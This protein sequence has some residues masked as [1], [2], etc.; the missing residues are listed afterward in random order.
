LGRSAS[1]TRQGAR[2]EGVGDIG[3]RTGAGVVRVYRA[4][5]GRARTSPSRPVAI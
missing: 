5:S 1:L 3:W 2:Y 4:R